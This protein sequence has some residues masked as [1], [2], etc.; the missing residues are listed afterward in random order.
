MEEMS[1]MQHV[2]RPYVTAGIALVGVSTIAVTP[3][4]A[5][6]IG[7][8]ARAV[9]LVDAWSDLLANTTAN[10]QNILNG[11]DS[12]A[13]SEVLSLL[14]TNP[15]GV[16]DAFANLDPTVMTTAPGQI[17]VELPP[18]LELGIANLGATGATLTALSEVAG[19]LTTNP[20]ESIATILNGFLNGESNISL[21]GG[22][23]DIPFYN[24]ILA[25]EQSVSVDLNLTAL[26][27]ALGLG[28]TDLSNLDLSSLLSQLGLGD[29]T[30]GSLFSD[31]GL[32]SDGLG[33]LLA[34]ATNPVT[35]LGGLLNLLG[36]DNLGSGDSITLGLTNILQG[37]G[38]DT[39]VDLNQ[40]S[41]SSVLTAFGI[42]PTKLLS[43]DSLLG[44]LGLNT[45]SPVPVDSLLSELGLTST[46]PVSLADLLNAAGLG[47]TNVTPDDLLSALGITGLGSDVNSSTLLSALG[48][49]SSSP[50]SLGDLLNAAGLGSTT[51][52]PDALLNVLGLDTGNTVTA[53]TLL[54]AIG[55]DPSTSV[56]LTLSDALED[57]LKAFDV[58][59][60]PAITTELDTLLALVGTTTTPTIGDLLSDLGINPTDVNLGSL[61]GDLGLT[62]TS[63]TVGDLLTD[64]GLSSNG[65]T[66]GNLLGDF[67]VP[68]GGLTL[69]DL[70]T[71]LGLSGNTLT[72]GD[73]LG[74]LNLTSNDLT[75]GG[76]LSDLGLT[77]TLTVGGL[78]SDL[79]LS[80]NGLTLGNLLGD[81]GIAPGD[82]L[83]IG[84]VL[85][86]LGFSSSTGDLTLGTL[87]SDLGNPFGSL[88]I[89]DLLNGLNVGDLL[90]DL[91]LSSLPV[92][93]TNLGDVSGLTLDDL[94]GDLGLGNLATVS[95]EPIGGLVT[96]LVDTVPQQILT[97]L[98]M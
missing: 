20:S 1:T 83:T 55:I 37:L 32:S 88:S 2:L 11:E 3:V 39:N 49:T 14:K 93:L 71:N 80:G 29:L 4:A 66:L 35:T 45:S 94:L 25:P 18:G 10:W 89:T 24:G 30:V 28:N 79:G 31:L 85:G 15:V 19:Q 34:N 87:L 62:G 82:N 33:T 64:L 69:G 84:G 60:T 40:L 92:D 59:I 5:P 44:V 91:G 38:L 68:P 26:V 70:L 8:Q 6:P 86:D 77:N 36:L 41:L 42:D 13:V 50:I 16:I 61:L 95:V 96:E 12:S 52:S 78:L 21:L 76:L 75:I 65:L 48:L 90:N 74:A 27:N 97:A 81:L 58:T 17:S 63:P 54:S 7:V 9:Q 23:I 22:I 72:V 43:S 98:G 53:D 57:V 51:V 46:S 47:T 56:S 73:L 67:N